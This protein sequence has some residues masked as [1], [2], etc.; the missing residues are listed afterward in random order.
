MGENDSK[1]V[2]LQSR[3]KERKLVVGGLFWR[4]RAFSSSNGALNLS[5]R[6]TPAYLPDLIHVPDPCYQRAEPSR[7]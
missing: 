3:A 4:G 7:N 1:I 2:I 6:R 5:I